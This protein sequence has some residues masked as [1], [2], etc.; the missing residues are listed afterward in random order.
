M[1]KAVFLDRDGTI[2]IDKGYVHTKEEFEYL[3]G[4][5]EGLQ[6]LQKAGFLL[7]IITNQSGIARGLFTEEEYLDFQKWISNSLK[8][9][10]IKIA[11]QYYCP[12]INSDNCECRKPKIAL[13]EKAARE[14]DI[15]WNSS[16]AIGD[17][18]R[19]LEVCNKK[20][21]KGYL[22][23]TDKK[24]PEQTNIKIVGSLK[25]AAVEIISKSYF[26]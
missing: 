17:K 9:Q 16:F 21:I 23:A 15:D 11:A 25:E 19:D 3:P 12:H 2:N 24:M 26:D 20:N 5:V 14:L 7:V 1:N 18:L 22:I 13:F 10:G 6:L 4:V 8:K